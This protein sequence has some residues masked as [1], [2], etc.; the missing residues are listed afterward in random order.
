[1]SARRN[2][3]SIVRCN[4]VWLYGTEERLPKYEGEISGVADVEEHNV[5]SIILKPVPLHIV[6]SV[7]WI[8]EF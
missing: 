4:E 3:T 1:V 6:D 2:G 8:D 5:E 7:W